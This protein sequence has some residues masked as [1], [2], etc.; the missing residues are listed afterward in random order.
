MI[1]E[2]TLRERRLVAIGILVALVVGTC[3][4][5][6][7]PVARSFAVRDSERQSLLAQY[8]KNASNINNMRHWRRE[9]DRQSQTKNRYSVQAASRQEA[10]EILREQIIRQFVKIGG[11]VRNCQEIEAPA[12][13][14]RVRLAARL[15]IF[16]IE[17]GIRTFQNQMPFAVVQTATVT[18]DRFA[19]ANPSQ[20]LDIKLEISAP[21]SLSQSAV[22]EQKQ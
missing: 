14:L 12:G 8:A 16:K 17:R 4:L 2:L 6:I 15:D 19:T 10:V 9:A 13:W 1:T 22:T 7:A 11:E 20:T 21:F 5:L 18:G 3:L